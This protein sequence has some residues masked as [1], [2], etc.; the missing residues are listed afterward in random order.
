MWASIKAVL[1]IL[2]TL[3]PWLGRKFSPE[4]KLERMV[5]KETKR[6]GEAKL[7]AE[8]L[9]RT[10]DKIDAQPEKSTKD[11]LESLNKD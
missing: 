11:L 7:K 8:K 10:Y 5:L 6:E 4:A 3:I 1:T 2:A 9:K